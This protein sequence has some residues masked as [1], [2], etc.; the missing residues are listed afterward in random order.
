MSAPLPGVPQAQ[1]PVPT[2]E[3]AAAVMPADATVA[4]MRAVARWTIM[5]TAAVGGLL[6]GGFPLAA[7]GKVHGLG[8]IA[9]AAGG[10][11]LAMVGVFWAIWWTGEVLT[12][13]SPRSG[14]SRTLPRR[15]SR[16]DHGRPRAVLRPVR[17][18]RRGTRPGLPAAHRRGREPDGTSRPRAGRGPE[19]RTAPG[20]HRGP[21]Q[22]RARHR[23][24]PGP[25]GT[26]PRLAGEGSPA[27]GP[28]ADDAVVARRRPRSG[29][30]PAG[31]GRG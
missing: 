20:P 14:R 28:G 22:H 21:R 12:P 24:P 7:I 15:P 10:L 4:D 31:H 2:G 23:A 19:R 3:Q 29:A 9:L 16:R 11:A 18:V 6:L 17:Q 8:D 1:D 5:A 13:G 26:R 25:G 30:V 27:Q